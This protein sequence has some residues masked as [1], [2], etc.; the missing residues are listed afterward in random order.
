MNHD[1]PRDSSSDGRECK[2]G[3][4]VTTCSLP[5]LLTDLSSGSV[6]LRS[7]VWRSET[8]HWSSKG[9]HGARREP[10]PRSVLPRPGETRF[11]F[12]RRRQNVRNLTTV[13]PFGTFSELTLLNKKNKKSGAISAEKTSRQESFTSQFVP[14]GS[15]EVSFEGDLTSAWQFSCHDLFLVVCVCLRSLQNFNH[16]PGWVWASLLAE[17]FS[18]NDLTWKPGGSS[19]GGTPRWVCSA[20]GPSPSR[21]GCVSVSRQKS[22]Q[23]SVQMCKWTNFNLFSQTQVL[24]R[25]KLVKRLQMTRK[26]WATQSGSEWKG[27]CHRSDSVWTAAWRRTSSCFGSHRGNHEASL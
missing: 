23:K 24:T 4:D 15:D 18:R 10:S 12:H 11:R 3:G 27:M 1:R 17:S 5:A 19:C 22:T 26:M 9:V 14:S 20:A 25:S 7:T 8:L 21:S 13:N 16:C 6:T 2:G